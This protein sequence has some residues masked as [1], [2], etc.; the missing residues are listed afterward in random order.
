MRS[1][2]GMGG[3]V[4]FRV[5]PLRYHLQR[6]SILFWVENQ[7]LFFVF[8]PDDGLQQK[9]H[10]C[11]AIFPRKAPLEIIIPFRFN[12]IFDHVG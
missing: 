8:R 5:K 2:K 12:T 11:S 10:E 1:S 4:F 6:S 9:T 3:K 7:R